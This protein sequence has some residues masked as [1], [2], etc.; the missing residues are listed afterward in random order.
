MMSRTKGVSVQE[1]TVKMALFPIL[2]EL[3][4][5]YL[6]FLDSELSIEEKRKRMIALNKACNTVI[7][8]DPILFITEE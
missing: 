5:L 4:C 6:D 8:I 7:K 3:K 2:T 1:I